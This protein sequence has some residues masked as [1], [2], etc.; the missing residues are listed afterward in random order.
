M[1]TA[2]NNSDDVTPEQVSDLQR[3]A[4]GRP[5]SPEQE[6]EARRAQEALAR[7]PRVEEPV[8][9][10]SIAEPQV[11]PP[12][13]NDFTVDSEQGEQSEDAPTQDDGKSEDAIPYW[14]QTR[15]VI[16]LLVTVALAAMG[17]LFSTVVESWFGV[18]RGTPLD[19][20]TSL[21]SYFPVE[22]YRTAP[23]I[24]IV[25]GLI[26]CAIAIVAIKRSRQGTHAVQIAVLVFS[27]I[28]TWNAIALVARSYTL[29]M[30]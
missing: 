17:F 21:A 11:S 18:Y 14:G 6:V 5:N 10:P 8:N 19:V 24:A 9:H 13:N 1:A 28:A 27:S 12:I 20:F 3:V 4:F 29:W 15:M 7:L 25:P 26:A 2:Q 23:L 30:M 16:T 22:M